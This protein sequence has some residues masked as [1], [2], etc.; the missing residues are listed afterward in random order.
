MR[1]TVRARGRMAF[2]SHAPHPQHKALSIRKYAPVVGL[3]VIVTLAVSN[4]FKG[5]P[6]SVEKPPNGHQARGFLPSHPRQQ[7]ADDSSRQSPRWELPEDWKRKVGGCR[8][9]G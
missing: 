1:R 7:E 6:I 8:R 4:F 9:E 2:K 3:T 5:H